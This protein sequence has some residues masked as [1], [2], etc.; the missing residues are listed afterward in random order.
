[1]PHAIINSIL[2]TSKTDAATRKRNQNRQR[3]LL[4]LFIALQFYIGFSYH[5]AQREN[6]IQAHSYVLR[7]TAILQAK[8]IKADLE[9]LRYQLRVIG[10]DILLDRTVSLDKAENFIAN[11]INTSDFLDAVVVFDANGDFIAQKSHFQL[12]DLLA[13][14]ALEEHSFR[15]S[16]YFKKFR[17]QNTN[18]DIF[19]FHSRGS[20]KN[21]VGFSMYRAIHDK[22]GNYL[23]GIVGLSND[24]V[25]QDRLS[26][27]QANGF[28]LGKGGVMTVFDRAASIQLA[29][30]GYDATDGEVSHEYIPELK[31]LMAYADGSTTVRNYVSPLDGIERLGVF[32]NVNNGQWV[33]SVAMDKSNM[34]RNWYVHISVTAALLIILALMQW[35]L[36]KH[37]HIIAH[38]RR[39]LA[40]E[41]CQDPLTGLANRRYF[42]S[43]VKN[44]CTLARRHQLPISIIALDLDYFK[45]IN[46]SYGHDGGDAVLKSVAE[47]LQGMLR[48]SDIAARFGGEEFVISM[49]YVNSEAAIEVAE[50]IRVKIAALDVF[51]NDQ[52]ISFTASFG[53]AQLTF[54]ELNAPEGINTALIRADR[55]L[56]R[57]KRAGRNTVTLAHQTLQDEAI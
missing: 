9:T 20:D 16:L 49:P 34:L 36:L 19:F 18:N 15:N 46:D 3:W 54:D 38:Q 31:E 26:Q 17:E 4:L 14:Q 53:V 39:I 5:C 37:I 33:L 40:Q 27:M 52:K 2:T 23:G 44:C 50:R 56:Y 41:A 45:K 42:T 1:M 22:K 8:N 25:M 29:R 24:R 57:S 10:E 43:Q 7:N 6:I 30:M 13:P 55:A 32:I 35:R 51:I 12:E 28:Y 11:E 21:R 48:S 47:L